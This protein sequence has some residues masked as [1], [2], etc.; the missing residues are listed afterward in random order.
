MTT[1][2]TMPLKTKY[3]AGLELIDT[4]RLPWDIYCMNRIG[5]NMEII[6]PTG[7]ASIDILDHLS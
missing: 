4:Y 5:R 3:K 6:I 1:V 2:A 7:A